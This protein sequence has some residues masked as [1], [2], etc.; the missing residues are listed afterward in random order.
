MLGF[1][2][3]EIPSECA[4]VTEVVDQQFMSQMARNCTTLCSFS[5]QRCCQLAEFKAPEL[6][7]AARLGLG[8]FCPTFN[9]STDSKMWRLRSAIGPTLVLA[10]VTS[11]CGGE[12]T[13]GLV[14]RNGIDTL[15][16]IPTGGD[17]TTQPPRTNQG[18]ALPLLGFGTELVWQS[19]NGVH[20]VSVSSS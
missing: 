12:V 6:L 13:A 8:V 2:D 1:I 9:S 18:R 14:N 4:R 17:V 10:L 19:I 15:S 5:L 3:F 16:G 20:P 11:H 7:P